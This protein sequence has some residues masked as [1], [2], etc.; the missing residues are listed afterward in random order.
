MKTT[1]ANALTSIFLFLLSFALLATLFSVPL[2]LWFL[3]FYVTGLVSFMIPFIVMVGYSAVLQQD[4]YEWEVLPKGLFVGFAAVGAVICLAFVVIGFSAFPFDGAKRLSVVFGESKVV[5]DQRLPDLDIQNAP[6][7]SH[8]LAIRKAQAALTELGTKASQLRLEKMVKQSVNGKLVWVGFLEPSGFFRW[9]ALDGS[10]GYVVVSASDYGDVK[11][12]TEINGEPLALRYTEGGYFGNNV[13][14]HAW[15]E[16]S[17]TDRIA[18]FSSEIDDEGRPF[19]VASVLEPT[20]GA[21]GFVTKG[22]LVIDAQT[23]E[24]QSYSAKDAPSW[25][26][27]IEP[28]SVIEAQLA[29]AGEFV[30]G[31]IN[32]ANEGTFKVSSIDQVFSKDGSSYWV[33]G[34]TNKASQTGVQ[35]FVFVNTRTKESFS[36]DVRG[37]SEDRAQQIVLDSHT[38]AYEASNPVPFMVNGRPTYVMSLSLGD[39]IY[40]YGM[41]D[42]ESETTF[43]SRDT[44]TGTLQAYLTART[45][46]GLLGKENVAAQEFSGAIKRIGQDAKTGQYKFMVNNKPFVFLAESEVSH[47]LAL[48]AP[49]DLVTVQGQT[50]N[51]TIVNVTV[52]SNQSLKEA[53]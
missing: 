17:M 28:A 2:N 50:F 25:V 6:L 22:A 26:D 1:V 47:E 30:N 45:N 10:P 14:R 18:D 52:F 39:A 46:S 35:R 23:G 33:A 9:R 8:D 32:F 51:E 20:V 41:V 53:N 34:V 42:I 44:L 48:S 29:D 19:Y 11:V 5:A 7:V 37:V 21:H 40:A 27:I 3:S 24:I 4:R 43:A 38:K 49:K 31:R 16:Y 36:Y 13:N 12:V 15:L